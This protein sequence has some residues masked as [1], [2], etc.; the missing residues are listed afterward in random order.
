M[1]LRPGHVM[2]D[3]EISMAP[4][5]TVVDIL[6]LHNMGVQFYY[7]NSKRQKSLSTY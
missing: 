7:L 1:V 5:F 6:N 4:T 3:Y 2:S